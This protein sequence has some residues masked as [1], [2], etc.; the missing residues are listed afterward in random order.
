MK[1]RRK[2]TSLDWKNA[3]DDVR[4]FVRVNEQPSIDL[5]GEDLFLHQLEKLKGA[6]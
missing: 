6:D 3:A 5:W 1:L 2:I 4:R